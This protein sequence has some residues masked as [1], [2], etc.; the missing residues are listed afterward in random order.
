MGGGGV[1]PCP[2]LL[3]RVGGWGNHQGRADTSAT[4]GLADPRHVPAPPSR[5]PAFRRFQGV[6]LGAKGRA[7]PRPASR[8]SAR[9]TPLLLWTPASSPR[10]PTGSPPRLSSRVQHGCRSRERGTAPA[11]GCARAGE[12]QGPGRRGAAERRR[13]R[14]RG[15]GARWV[16]RERAAR[17][18]ASPAPL[19]FPAAP[20]AA[21]LA[22][23]SAGWRCCSAG[24]DRSPAE[25]RAAEVLEGE[26]ACLVRGGEDGGGPSPGQR[27]AWTARGAR[28]RSPVVPAAGA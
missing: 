1:A 22:S 24:P 4:P 11:Q 25:M 28:T 3:D 5:G 12:G 8:V 19:P 7:R 20:R 16:G 17:P 2:S 23:L 13:P 6:A 14:R 9:L 10:S 21:G 26:R 15:G 18:P 27:R